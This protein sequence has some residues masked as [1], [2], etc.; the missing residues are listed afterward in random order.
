MDLTNCAQIQSDL[1]VKE[2]LLKH[3]ESL[4]SRRNTEIENRTKAEILDLKKAYSNSVCGKDLDAEYCINLDSQINSLINTI[5]EQTKLALYDNRLY[6]TVDSLKKKLS[7]LR[8]EYETKGCLVKVEKV[9]SATVQEVISDFT[10]LDQQRIA[11]DTNYQLKQ[12]IFFGGLVLVAGLVI[13]TMFN[14]NKK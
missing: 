14:K 6:S 9:K 11:E 8:L 7:E 13:L 10:S 2:A 3:L 4:E 5:A 1:S 12:R